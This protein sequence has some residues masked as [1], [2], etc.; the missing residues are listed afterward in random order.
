MPFITGSIFAVL[1]NE[2]CMVPLVDYADMAFEWL[3]L[4]I[5]TCTLSFIW[6]S[7]AA[8]IVWSTSIRL[9]AN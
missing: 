9:N 6:D 1:A 8:W 2:G 7:I 4:S 3:A 5:V